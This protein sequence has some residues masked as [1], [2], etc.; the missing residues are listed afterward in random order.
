MVVHCPLRIGVEAP[1]SDVADDADDLRVGACA[2]VQPFADGVLAGEDAVRQV[3][4][5][6][7]HGRSREIVRLREYAAA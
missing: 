3:L 1:L 2:K 7:D 6:N 4:V 5:Y